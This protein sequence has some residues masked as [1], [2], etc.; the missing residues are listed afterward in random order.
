MNEV[1]D[2]AFIAAKVAEMKDEKAR[3]IVG[4]AS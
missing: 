2:L 1:I 3:K 4:G